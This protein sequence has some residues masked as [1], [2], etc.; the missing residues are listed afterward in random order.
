[1]HRNCADSGPE[2]RLDRLPIYGSQAKSYEE[3]FG[4]NEEYENQIG[5]LPLRDTSALSEQ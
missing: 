1:M 2:P 5:N 3:Q 4:W